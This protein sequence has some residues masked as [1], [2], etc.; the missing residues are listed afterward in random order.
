MYLSCQNWLGKDHIK[1]WRKNINEIVKRNKKKGKKEQTNV[2]RS[3]NSK[4]KQKNPVVLYNMNDLSFI[5][6][7]EC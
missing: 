5:I 4:E 1:M 6:C 2:K 3:K 7:V